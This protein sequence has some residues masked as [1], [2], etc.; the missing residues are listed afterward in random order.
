MKSISYSFLALLILSMISCS[1]SKS[2]LVDVKTPARVTF[3]A[4]VANIAILDN[5]AQNISDPT[6][7]ATGYNVYTS[8]ITYLKAL[9]QFISDENFFSS[10]AIDTIPLRDDNTAEDIHLLSQNKVKQLLEKNQVDGIIALDIYKTESNPVI[11]EASYNYYIDVTATYLSAIMSIYGP[12]GKRIT[13]TF[14]A[15][16]DT[17]YQA[18]SDKLSIDQETINNMALRNADNTTKILL[19]Y[20]QKQERLLFKTGTKNDQAANAKVKEGDWKG[21]AQLW[22]EDYQIEK[23]NK[24]KSKLAANIA[25]SNEMLM[26]IDYAMEW[27]DSAMSLH[28][29]GR[30]NYAETLIW[31]KQRLEDRK[32]NFPQLQKQLKGY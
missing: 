32:K 29:Y 25:L 12:D 31:Y 2:I 10:V 15:T 11:I 26:D 14:G 7:D 8:K 1:S 30:T 24:K 9:T 3:P 17:I 18:I 19:P 16:S 22:G 4:S 20:W 5:S 27:I 21:A 28:E 6:V 23:S 13:D